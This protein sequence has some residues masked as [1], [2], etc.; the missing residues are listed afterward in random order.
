M[1]KNNQA[2]IFQMGIILG[3]V[4]FVLGALESWLSGGLYAASDPALWADMTGN[5]WFTALIADMI[6][7]LVLSLVYTLF[8]SSI[9]DQGV[10]KGIQYGF[11]VWLVGTVPGLI[12]TF[13]TLAVPAELV[14]TWVVTGLLNYIVVGLI[15]GVMYQPKA[16]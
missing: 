8:Y 3:V 16:A 4:L 2:K 14:V 11:W 13:L 15:L 5:W 6:I 12:M 10:G 1:I 7:G 9:P